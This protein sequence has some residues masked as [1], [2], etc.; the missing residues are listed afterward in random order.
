MRDKIRDE[1][2]NVYD[3]YYTEEYSPFEF[4]AQVGAAKK[5]LKADLMVDLI[6]DVAKNEH[7]DLTYHSALH[8]CKLFLSRG[9]LSKKILDHFANVENDGE[10]LVK[11]GTKRTA[12]EKVKIDYEKIKDKYKGM[13]W[14]KLNSFDE[15]FKNVNNNIKKSRAARIHNK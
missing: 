9:I 4:G 15:T 14:D 7:I 12:T 8:L 11:R 6:Y 3:E 13:F 1:L 5:R 10:N 2:S